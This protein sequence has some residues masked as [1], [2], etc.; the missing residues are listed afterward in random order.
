[1]TKIIYLLAM[2]IFIGSCN[3]N[4]TPGKPPVA[5][6]APLAK[7]LDAYYNDRMELFPV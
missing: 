4:S 6:N 3:S 2:I 5:A 1:M 7:M